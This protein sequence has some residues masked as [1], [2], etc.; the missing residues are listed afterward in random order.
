MSNPSLTIGELSNSS[1]KKKA[2]MPGLALQLDA[3]RAA[4]LTALPFS[5]VSLDTWTELQS[6]ALRLK[7]NATAL[8]RRI[9][10]TASYA[11][12]VA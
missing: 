11:D 4:A 3:E 7:D 10:V 5:E 6:I 12:N 9:A 2:G 8:N 1:R